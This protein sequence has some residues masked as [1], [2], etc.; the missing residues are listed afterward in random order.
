[1]AELREATRGRERAWL[2]RRWVVVVAVAR[3]RSALAVWQ[4]SRTVVRAASATRCGTSRSSG[5]A[6]NYDLDPALLAAV[7]YT[8]SRFDADARSS[9]GAI[10]L[11]QLLPETAEGIALRTGGHRVRRRRPLRPGAQRPLRLLV[12]AQP[13]RPLR[14]RAHG[15]RRVPRG[16]GERRPLAQRRAR[17]R[18]PGDAE[19]RRRGSRS[20]KRSTRDSYA[21]ELGLR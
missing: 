13:A 12:P 7:I 17:D 5:H 4:P 16:P 9:A 15:A 14:R 3:R 20:V 19:L 21:D 1:M 18:V 10:G 11:M 2:D 6:E 8:E